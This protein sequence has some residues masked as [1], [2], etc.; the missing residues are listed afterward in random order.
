[1]RGAIESSL[2][3]ADALFNSALGVVGPRKGQARGETL[4]SMSS[5]WSITVGNI[6]HDRQSRSTLSLFVADPCL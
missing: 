6:G 5:T 2:K 3:Y 4:Q 1:M